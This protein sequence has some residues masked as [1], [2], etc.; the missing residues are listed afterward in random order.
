MASLRDELEELLGADGLGLL[1]AARGGRRVHIP[2]AA[3]PGHWLEAALGHE[4]A[5]R[6]AA[7]YGGCR[8]YV[9]LPST[10]RADRD[11]RIRELRSRGWSVARIAT[12]VGLS[13]RRV[14][15]IL[16]G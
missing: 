7:R 12:E 4:R 10:R 3:L 1:A 16:G 9:P 13:D 15:Q 8:L 14:I 2:K 5:E 11:G 6:L